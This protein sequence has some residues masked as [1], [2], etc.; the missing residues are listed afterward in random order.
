MTDVG[1]PSTSDATTT[2]ART[3]RD[4]IEAQLYLVLATADATGR[5]WSTP[6]YF[7]HVDF[8]SFFW[9][10]SPDVR[11]SGNIAVRPEVG[12]VVFDSQVPISTG[13]AVYMTGVARLVD[14]S[15]TAA[16]LE[17]FTRRSLTHGGRV[18]T[19]EDVRPEAGLRLYHAAVDAHWILDKDGQP[20][21]RIAVDLR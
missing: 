18:W 6:V 5:P 7:A 19:A 12:I 3:A 16:G 2:A 15:E 10:S 14:E 8:T 21:H 9:L 13:Q 20:D 4:I 1:D 17:V 11:H